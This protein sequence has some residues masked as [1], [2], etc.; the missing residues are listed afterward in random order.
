MITI[1]RHDYVEQVNEYAKQYAKSLLVQMQTASSY[2]DPQYA[3]DMITSLDTFSACIRRQCLHDMSVFR[4]DTAIG[5]RLLDDYDTFGDYAYDMLHDCFTA[6]N[7][8]LSCNNKLLDELKQRLQLDLSDLQVTSNYI[9]LNLFSGIAKLEL[10]NFRLHQGVGLSYDM[11]MSGHAIHTMNIVERITPR[12]K[13]YEELAAFLDALK[14]DD[15]QQLLIEWTDLANGPLMQKKANA[16]LAW[17]V[18]Y[19]SMRQAIDNAVFTKQ[20]GY[21]LCTMKC[22]NNHFTETLYCNGITRSVDWKQDR[23]KL[24]QL[25]Y[26]NNVNFQFL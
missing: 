10:S 1:D 14:S 3:T 18:T 7:E 26:V 4:K 13:F 22:N 11:N 15:V 19:A 24:A 20:V 12:L 6:T 23:G 8:V 17:H 9:A 25:D 5:L 21:T 2:I 16:D